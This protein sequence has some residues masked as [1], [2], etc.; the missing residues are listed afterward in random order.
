MTYE[1]GAIVGKHQLSTPDISYITAWHGELFPDL[2]ETSE[3]SPQ[4]DLPHR[5]WA[6]PTLPLLQ[7]VVHK[8][9]EL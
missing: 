9:H 3:Q 6:E 2:S 7:R 4:P 8:L 5:A 1:A